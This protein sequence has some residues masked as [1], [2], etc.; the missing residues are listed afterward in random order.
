MKARRLQG[1]K[2][3]LTCCIASS[4]RPG[5]IASAAEDGCICWH[6]LR[7]EDVLYAI[8]VGRGSISSLCFKGENEDVICASA[9]TTIACLDVRL[10]PSWKPLET[11]D[12]NKEEINQIAFSSKSYFLASADD[13]GDVKIIDT[14]QQ[15]LYKTL[16]AVH[17][18]I[19]ST[20]QFLS[21]KPWT[22]ITG[23]LDSILALWDFSKGRAFD[24][25]NY[26]LP[27]LDGRVS[28]SGAGQC[29]NPAFVHSIA[30][31]EIEILPGLERVCAVAKGDGVIDVIKL[32]HEPS[33][34]KSSCSSKKSVPK[35]LSIG[36]GKRVQLDYTL[37]GHTAA[38]SCVSFSKFG[39]KGK[40]LISGGNDA[41]IKLWNWSKQFHDAPSTC[42]RDLILSIDL[43]RKV[44]WL[45]TTP[46]LENLIV[47][48][49]SKVLKVYTVS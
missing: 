27:N 33:S 6:D 20:V 37:G 35:N 36:F 24:V 30:I 8:D 41:S 40:F 18:S 49:T 4:A 19:C 11:Y 45:C 47:C 14:R 25:I 2:K 31:P 42:D 10:A 3:E 9:G 38:V 28:S 21:W 17:T 34:T 48:D 44:N 15:C 12:H 16:R 39:E 23:G 32:E 7:C 13:T 1:H 29:Y 5:L 43:K 46:D 26:G 22:A